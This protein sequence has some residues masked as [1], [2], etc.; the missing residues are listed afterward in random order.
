M[1]VGR[2]GSPYGI[3]GWLKVISHTSPFDNLFQYSHWQVPIKNVWR[4]VII[5]TGK[6]HGTNL[7]VKLKG[8]DDRNE[9]R[10]FT[11]LEIAI[12]RHEFPALKK[13]EYYCVDLIGLRVVNI[14]NVELGHIESILATGSNDVIRIKDKVNRARLLPYIDEVVKSIDLDKRLVVVNWDAEF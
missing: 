4:T 3:R 14:E 7:I 8:C 13:G 2:F 11:N 10:L 6:V 1:I 9:A 5:S 12:A